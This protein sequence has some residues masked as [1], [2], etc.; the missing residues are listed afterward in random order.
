MIRQGLQKLPWPMLLLACATLGLAPF[1][2]SPH[3]WD[4]L[5]MLVEGTLRA[6]IDIFDFVLHGS[7]WILMA[8]KGISGLI[9]AAVGS[10]EKS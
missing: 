8:A 2:P 9:P 3:I 4:K 10:T 1:S 5:G 6:P 7:P